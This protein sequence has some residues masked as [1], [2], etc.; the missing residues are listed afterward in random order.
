MDCLP[1]AAARYSRSLE[2]RIL[3]LEQSLA[4]VVSDPILH[5]RELTLS[6]LVALGLPGLRSAPSVYRQAKAKV[7]P[8][9][10]VRGR[11]YFVLA[12]VRASL[13][14]GKSEDAVAQVLSAKR[15]APVP[16]ALARVEEI[17]NRNRRPRFSR[18]PR[19]LRRGQVIS[20]QK[21]A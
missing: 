20:A 15:T 3:R 14:R 13:D 7:I 12:D 1:S 18:F 5:P 16:A 17:L 9:R 21:C 8:F 19:K 2:E 4:R 10:R 11:Y 6:E